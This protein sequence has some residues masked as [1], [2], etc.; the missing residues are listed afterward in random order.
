M[1]ASHWDMKAKIKHTIYSVLILSTSSIYFILAY[2]GFNSQKIDYKTLEK[3][4]G[5]VIERGITER[6]SG[7]HYATVF[8]VSITGLNQILGLYRMD[9]D[10]SGLIDKLRPGEVITVY[11]INRPNDTINIDLVQ[12][13]KDGQIIIE[14]TEYKKKES[15]L[16]YIGLIGG[17]FTIGL[18]AWYYNKYVRLG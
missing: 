7:R 8:Y 9:K 11:F 13:E 6:K 16:I 5:T 14:E 1:P 12:I 18:T 2:K 3:H 10:Y 4:T 15:A 17:L